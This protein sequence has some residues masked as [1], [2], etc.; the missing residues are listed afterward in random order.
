MLGR[1]LS[2]FKETDLAVIVDEGTTLKRVP[3]EF[4]FA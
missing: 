2:N 3:L 1:H 4:E